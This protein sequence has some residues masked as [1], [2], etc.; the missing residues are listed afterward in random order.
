MSSELGIS[1]TA[2][3]TIP[4]NKGSK[5]YSM[6]EVFQV[7]YDNKDQILLS[8]SSAPKQTQESY[9]NANPGQIYHLDLQHSSSNVRSA[10]DSE[11]S[12]KS[13]Q[14]GSNHYEDKLAASL[15]TLS[16]D[17]T[18]PV[19]PP[20]GIPGQTVDSDLI[21]P[22]TVPLLNSSQI[23][24]LYLDPSGNEQGPFNGD[25]MQ[26]WL[27]DGYLTL[28]LQIKRVQEPQ[29][30]TLKELCEAV[31]NYIQPFKVSLPDLTVPQPSSFL[32]AQQQ[33]PA[34]LQSLSFANQQPQFH[35]FMS[36]GSGNLGVGSMRL[37]NTMNSQS[38]LFS[39]DF[40]SQ[41]DPFAAPLTPQG[42]NF[43]GPNQFGID[44]VN[45]GAI[46]G[47]SNPLAGG[48][49][50]MP[51]LL[52]QQI[53]SQTQ[54]GLSRNNSG[55]GLDTTSGGLM[56]SNPGTPV[57]VAPPLA[58]QIN[59]PA[60]LSPWIAATAQSLSRVSSPFVAT[61][62]MA[63]ETRDAA[64]DDHVLNKFHTS[65]VTDI[66]ND[67]IDDKFTSTNPEFVAPPL[68][69]ETVAAVDPVAVQLQPEPVVAAEPSAI[70][71]EKAPAKSPTPEPE[72]KSNKIVRP[73]VTTPPVEAAKPAPP[74]QPKLAPWAA[75]SQEPKA[76]PPLTLKEIQQLEAEK[77]EQQRKELRTAQAAA[78]EAEAKAW[79]MEEKRT[80][81]EK[82]S[83]PKTSSWAAAPTLNKPVVKKTLAEIQK[84]ESEAKA[85]AAAAAAAAVSSSV[86][87]S[88]S[89]KPS[90]ASALT[91]STPS[92]NAWTTVTSKKPPV[93]K[94]TQPVI[95]SNTSAT[96]ASPQMFRS[97]SAIKPVS[98]SVNS[99][100][101][102]EEFLV[103]ARSAMTNLYPT[104][105]KDDLLDIFVTL[106]LN[107]SD[108]SQL[109]A[110]TIYSSSAT[111]DGRRFAQE[112]LKRRQ[113]VEQQVGSSDEV[114]WSSAIIASADKVLAVDDDGWS[115]NV[116]SKKRGKK[117]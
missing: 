72:I 56:S 66:L 28:D 95:V 50:H 32:Q 83:L 107:G 99:S 73:T 117:H 12:E 104:V 103:W 45:A 16:T 20:P 74:Q 41:Q 9:K 100:A 90:F 23:E 4:P 110:E 2:N 105:S 62:S 43:A 58:S 22:P 26:E 49:L 38:N 112:F 98:T 68:E 48:S 33:Q 29:Y 84:E 87:P 77:Y 44:T 3:I 24:W 114:S 115:T 108:S 93:K 92:D 59:Q 101:L 63:T 76:N 40:I 36:N 111:M 79:A 102:R 10:I 35:Q 31:Q 34:P 86:A 70:E 39:N 6:D 11:I 94:P 81:A 19:G 88:S 78:A 96:K 1:A 15:A 61:S 64:G 51:T 80:L 5:R 53:Q 82:P 106:P 13:H 89:S 17:E 57:S 7:W 109:I 85:A 42:T 47:F 97:A 65:V 75:A 46:G 52:Q 18:N 116:K 67:G 71:P 8:L 54:P 60:P 30:R 55:W 113:K 91:T 25:M 21:A 37:N 69:P 14:N 27:T